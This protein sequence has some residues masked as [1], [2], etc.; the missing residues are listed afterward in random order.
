MEFFFFGNVILILNVLQL[1][2]V[3]SIRFCYTQDRVPRVI[4][5]QLP[6]N[7]VYNGF[8]TNLDPQYD[9]MRNHATKGVIR[10]KEM[11]IDCD[12]NVLSKYKYQIV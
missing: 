3:S 2:S 8:A 12:L 1:S 5:I 11:E 10:E 9:Y 7:A 4:T 6:S